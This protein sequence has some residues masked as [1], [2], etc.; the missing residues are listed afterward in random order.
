[1]LLDVAPQGERPTL[2]A[3]LRRSG[4]EIPV[5]VRPPGMPPTSQD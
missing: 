5:I 1:V 3:R 4:I 2:E